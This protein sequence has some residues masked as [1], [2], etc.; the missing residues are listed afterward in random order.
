MTFRRWL[1]GFGLV[2]DSKPPRVAVVID[3]IAGECGAE[4]ASIETLM[5]RCALDDGG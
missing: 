5:I 1:P 2:V 4:R 3:Q